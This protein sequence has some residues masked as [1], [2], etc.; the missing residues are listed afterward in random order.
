MSSALDWLQLGILPQRAT[1]AQCKH[2]LYREQG[3]L[4]PVRLHFPFLF[5]I[6]LYSTP[7]WREEQSCP[8]SKAAWIRAEE[9]GR[10]LSKL[11]VPAK[12]EAERRRTPAS[13]PLSHRPR[14]EKI[15]VLAPPL[16]QVSLGEEQRPA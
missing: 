6:Y 3:H 16:S 5:P 2:I 15:A 14:K 7:R 9:R 10:V 11:I 4:A 13:A 1:E 12:Q 8:S